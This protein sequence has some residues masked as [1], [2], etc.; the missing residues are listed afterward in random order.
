MSERLI[1]APYTQ[2]RSDC[3]G[4]INN[5]QV[6]IGRVPLT[7]EKLP[8]LILYR[9]RQ[10]SGHVSLLTVTGETLYYSST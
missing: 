6:A 7:I 1:A 5:R 10:Q 4:R 9:I 8:T 3:S 2:Q